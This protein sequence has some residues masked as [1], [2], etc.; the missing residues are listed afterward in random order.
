MI[1]RGEGG[2]AAN[3]IWVWNPIFVTEGR[4]VTAGEREKKKKERR[5]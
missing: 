1:P 3:K 4:K 5:R 2:K